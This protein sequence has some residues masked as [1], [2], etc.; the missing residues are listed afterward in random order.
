M[1]PTHTKITKIQRALIS[2]SDKTGLEQLGRVLQ[3]RGVEILSSG[4]TG[5]G[6]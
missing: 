3:N 5:K 2:V 6:D 4:G 1:D